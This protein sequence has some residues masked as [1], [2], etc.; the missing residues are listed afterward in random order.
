MSHIMLGSR[1]VLLGEFIASFITFG[2]RDPQIAA[3]D[4]F[5]MDSLAL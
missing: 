2:G 4:I 1:V 3:T 5:K